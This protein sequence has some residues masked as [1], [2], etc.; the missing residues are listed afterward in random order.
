MGGAFGIGLSTG[1]LKKMLSQVKVKVPPSFFASSIVAGASSRRR[2]VATSW[3]TG[4]VAR[5][6]RTTASSSA[7]PGSEKKGCG[8]VFGADWM[9]IS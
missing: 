7:V 8:I 4:G 5:G 9:K 1:A 3:I 6:A 2:P